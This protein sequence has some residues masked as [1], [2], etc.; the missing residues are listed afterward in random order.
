MTESEA[1]R[2]V[3][4]F[5]RVFNI[6][7]NGDDTRELRSLRADLAYEESEEVYEA[8]VNNSRLEHVAKELADVV[9]VAFGAAVSLGIDLDEALR[10]VH[11]SNMSK[12]NPDGTVSYREDGKVLKPDTYRVPDLTGVVYSD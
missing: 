4:E 8:L 12:R 10:R 5:H 9:Y 2:M 6:V 11:A 1:T 7:I 3:I